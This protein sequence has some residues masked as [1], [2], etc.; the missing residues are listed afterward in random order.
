MTRMAPAAAALTAVFVAGGAGV[1][2]HPN[3]QQR[4]FRSGV[5]AINVA[6]VVRDGRNAVTGL[7][8]DDF[9]LLDNGVPQDVQLVALDGVPLDV[10]MV[11]DASGS[12]SGP[13]LE[14]LRRDVGELT[15]LLEPDDRV[16]AL[17]FSSDVSETVPMQPAG[18]LPA[19]DLSASSGSTAFFN[20][21]VA[22]LVR[23]VEAQR[24]HLVVAF[25]DAGDNVSLIG[26]RD[27]LEV[28]KHSDAV[29]Q[30]VL[31]G[32]A[33]SGGTG[34]LPFSGPGSL[35]PIGEAADL[36]GGGVS[37][38]NATRSE[39][40]R[41]AQILGEFRSSYVLWFTPQGV[42]PD[43]WHELSVRVK[44]SN[45]TVRARAGYVGGGR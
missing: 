16:R 1:A 42:E 31:R 33:G 14:Q 34:W 32:R 6:V 22:A 3:A 25:T 41:F 40:E 39:K 8:A 43:G 27:V 24:P 44:S 23:P 35:R 13:A 37:S 12:V 28:A 19:F 11:I 45:F 9:E 29:L 15:G 7:G 38:P 18:S 26:A 20:A 17:S 5:E 4:V 10:T 21:L 30:V 36:T 2:G